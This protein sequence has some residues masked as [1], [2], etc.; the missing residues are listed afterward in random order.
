MLNDY[1]KDLVAGHTHRLGAFYRTD[2]NGVN[3]AIENG[4]LCALDMEYMK[5]FPNWQLGFSA[6]YAL[7]FARVQTFPI[8]INH[9]DFSFTFE[10]MTY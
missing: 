6:G 7:D 2:R 4:C 1:G 9:N 10:R 8:A 3:V 5:G